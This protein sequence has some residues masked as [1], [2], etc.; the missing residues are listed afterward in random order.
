M[1]LRT[2]KRSA[3]LSTNIL[4]WS[5]HF[6]TRTHTERWGCVPKQSF[7]LAGFLQELVNGQQ[8]FRQTSLNGVIT[9]ERELTQKDGAVYRNNL[10]N[11]LDFFKNWWKGGDLE[12]IFDGES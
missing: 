10:S 1:Q 8:N 5:Y 12:A 6:G 9:L 3:K 11:S 2:G 4:E 7:K